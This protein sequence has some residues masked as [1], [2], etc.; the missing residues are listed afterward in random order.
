MNVIEYDKDFYILDSGKVRAFLIVGESRA[1]LIDTCFKE[2]RII[3]IVKKITN[4]P[5]EVILTHGDKDHIGGVYHFKKCRI[6]IK[7][8]HFIQCPVVLSYLR[9][10]DQINVGSYCF[11]VID[12]P[13]HTYGSIMLL[14][15]NKKLLL[16]GD[17][18]QK[19]P[20]YMF[21]KHRNLDLYIESLKN[22]K[23]IKD[24]E[25]ILPSHHEYPLKKEYID[26]CL[27]DAL[28]LKNK[29]L[30]GKKHPTLSCFHYIGENIE[31]Y[32]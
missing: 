22:I 31:F 18:I 5:I 30:Q 16:S 27:R 29:E 3:E 15:R 24:I 21:G 26:Y 2:D 8:S 23:Y 20:I 32:Y 6:H 17:S 28:A 25:I 1:I 7:D 4:K 13:G 14:D 10:R 19:G 12:M 11:E 9:T